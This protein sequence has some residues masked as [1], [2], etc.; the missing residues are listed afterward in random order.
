M[1]IWQLARALSIFVLGSALFPLIGVNAQTSIQD[2]KQV[3]SPALRSEIPGS[4]RPMVDSFDF[5][6]RDE[7][8]PMRDGATLHTV[9][10]IP[11]SGGKVP[12]LLTRTPSPARRSTPVR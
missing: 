9:I 2:N 12:I 3:Q 1:H 10:L 5:S 4:F 6:R 11:K 8:I 7:Q